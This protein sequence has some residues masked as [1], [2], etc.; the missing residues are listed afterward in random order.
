MLVDSP[1]LRE[2]GWN[3]FFDDQ[4]AAH[5]AAGL[6]PARVAVQH[7]GA[8]VVYAD[9]GELRAELSGRLQ[10]DYVRR[11]P[12]RLDF[13][14]R[15]DAALPGVGDWV[16]VSVRPSERAATIRATLSR[17]TALSRKEPW[18]TAEEQLLAANVDTLFVVCA[19][20]QA[21]DVYAGANLRRL[22]RYLA[23]ARESGAAPILLLTKA[24]LRPDAR[25]QALVLEASLA[26]PVVVT[27]A[28]T[29]DGLAALTPH[30]AVGAT[31]ALIG[32]SGVGKSTLINAL[33]GAD[34][35]PTRETR[36]D[37]AGRHTTAR[38][39]LVRL[40]GR[41]L[42]IDTPGLRELQLWDAGAGLGGT[43]GDI[44]QLAGAC[45]FRDCRHAGETGCAVLAAVA[46]GSVEGARLDA[47]RRMLRELAHL[48]A[49]QSVRAKAGVR[50]K[51]RA[52]ARYI[53]RGRR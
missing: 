40:P 52:F 21:E 5:A 45:R 47:Y 31:A 27:S 3:P 10:G 39:E 4:F 14:A 25:E 22:E 24:D 28:R 15:V 23:T 41:G 46:A 6:A 34:V 13:S 35:F 44:E 29:S 26:V 42:I 20:A 53:R 7:R 19:L 1:R 30:L 50:H 48:E 17:R 9:A 37:G 33:L 11:E 36:D 51:N 32:S 2:L 18:R 12:A 16:A 38:R 43:F 49:K 8:Y